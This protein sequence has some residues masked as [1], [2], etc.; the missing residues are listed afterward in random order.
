MDL[1][2]DGY[3]FALQLPEDYLE[4]ALNYHENFKKLKL[5]ILKIEDIIV[6]KTS[7]LNSRDQEDI[8]TLAKT[9]KIDLEFLKK[10][11]EQICKS[12]AGKE[13]DFRYHFEL[14]LKSFFS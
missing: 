1:F 2:R 14:V 3:I 8:K 13:E 6:T 4:L 11:F 5:K 12:Y 10:R 9:G 7:R